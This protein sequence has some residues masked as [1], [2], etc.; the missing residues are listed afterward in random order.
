M[1]FVFKEMDSVIFFSR[2]PITKNIS[3]IN[4]FLPRGE[5]QMLQKCIKHYMFGEKPVTTNINLYLMNVNN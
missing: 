4:V 3:K 5:T 2:N 1:A